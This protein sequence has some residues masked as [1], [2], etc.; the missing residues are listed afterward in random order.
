MEEVYIVIRHSYVRQSGCA[1]FRT[2]DIVSLFGNAEEAKEGMLNDVTKK[3]H[4]FETDKTEDYRLDYETTRDLESELC[5]LDTN[6]IAY[7]YK[8]S[9]DIYEVKGKTEWKN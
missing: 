9:I 4:E 6:G 5:Y 1:Y 2:T 3:K 7:E 8:W